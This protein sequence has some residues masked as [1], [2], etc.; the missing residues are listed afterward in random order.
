MVE[1]GSYWKC[2]KDGRSTLYVKVIANGFASNW[3]NVQI[4]DKSTFP[5]IDKLSI[6]KTEFFI[7]FMPLTS[8]EVELL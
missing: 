3:I 8:L 2:V 6:N 1:V 4:L 7:D 5:I